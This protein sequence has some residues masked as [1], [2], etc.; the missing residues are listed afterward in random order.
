MALSKEISLDF[1]MN[2]TAKKLIHFITFMIKAAAN[3]IIK[4]RYILYPKKV[5]ISS[6]KQNKATT[7]IIDSNV[8][9]I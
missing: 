3:G 7:I 1:H 6:L 8:V 9:I 2:F 4:I 5:E